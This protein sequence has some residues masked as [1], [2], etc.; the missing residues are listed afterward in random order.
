M[1]SSVSA[2][3]YT[4]DIRIP[5]YSDVILYITNKLPNIPCIADIY[6][7]LAMVYFIP[8]IHQLAMVY[9]L[10]Y[11]NFDGVYIQRYKTCC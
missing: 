2:K 9:M 1:Y 3:C 10:C 4:R 11:V 5:F 7:L 8:H 6:Y